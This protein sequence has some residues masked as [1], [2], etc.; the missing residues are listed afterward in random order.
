MAF[1]RQKK[2]P[3]YDETF[4]PLVKI[5]LGKKGIKTKSASEVGKKKVDYFRGKD[6]KKFLLENGALLKKKCQP[7]LTAAVRPGGD[8]PTTDEDV[9]SIGD[10]L[11]TRQF[12][13][14]AMYKPIN[15]TSKKDGASEKPSVKKW[16]DRLIRTPNQK[17]ECDG[18]YVIT[19]EGD[20]AMQ[21]LFLALIIAGVLLACMFPVWPFWAKVGIWYVGVLFLSL[22]FGILIFRLI[23]FAMFWIVGFDFWVFPNINDEYCGFLDSFKPFYSW[24]KRSDDAMM[25]LV[26]FVSLTITALAVQQIAETTSMADVQDFVTSSYT[27]VLDWGVEKLTA[28]PTAEREALP[29]LADLEN[30]TAGFNDDLTADDVADDDDDAEEVEVK[31]KEE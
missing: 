29:N 18:Y 19:Y 24:E 9:E 8:A 5:L 15:P 10:E 31:D 12:C 30:E 26:R 1:W 16:P 27:D 7:A 17:F 20:T 4:E 22:Y 25:L 14:K 23:F 6:F 28:L 2:T 11:I 3:K 21:H 13:Y